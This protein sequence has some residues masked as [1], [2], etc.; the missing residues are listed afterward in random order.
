MGI[1]KW[2]DLPAYFAEGERQ[3]EAM[4]DLVRGGWPLEAYG[5]HRWIVEGITESIFEDGT[6]LSE[7]SLAVAEIRQQITYQKA[8]AL[9]LSLLAVGN[10]PDESRIRPMVENAVRAMRELGT[11]PSWNDVDVES[12]VLDLEQQITQR[13]E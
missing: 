8:R 11:D 6:P 10:A 1:V 9:A 4:R 7:A 3:T 2:Q 5:S 12:L 13:N